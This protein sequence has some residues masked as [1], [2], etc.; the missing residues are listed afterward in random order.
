MLLADMGADV[1]RINRATQ[2]DPLALREI[3]DRGRHIIQLDLKSAEDLD[4]ALQLIDRADALIEGFR[5]GVMERL[6]LGPEVCSARNP[7]LVY[8]RVT[9]WGQ[10]GPLSQTAGHDID[11]I[12]LTGALHAIGTRDAPILPLNLIGDFGG[13]GLLLA[14]GM[15]CA[16]LEAQRSGHGQVVDAAM[17]DGAALLMAMTYALRA[18]GRWNNARA[19]NLL[20]GGAPFYD[21]YRCADGKFVA[22]G[23]LE[24]QFLTELLMKLDITDARFRPP[25]EP[26]LWP[27]LRDA[28]ARAIAQKTRDEWQEIFGGSDACVAPVLDL[29]E[30]P[31]HPHNASRTTFIEHA[32]TTQP[33]PAPR[34]SRTP[35]EVTRSRKLTRKEALERWL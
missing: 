2:S 26:A 17:V 23:A 24:P 8:G 18:Q 1:L 20:D 4:V 12:A 7:K 6:G 14:F 3:F 11:Y 34:F 16:V 22:L 29:D 35:G 27:A 25:V 13:G 21:T 33:A 31:R 10:E 19:S 15:L 9:G 5:P 28:I 30:A 32:G